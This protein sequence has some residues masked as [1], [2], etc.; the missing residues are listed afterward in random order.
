MVRRYTNEEKPENIP[1]RNQ[2]KIE[3]FVRLVDSEL[4]ERYLPGTA[5]RWTSTHVMVSFIDHADQA[6]PNS[7]MLAWVRAEDVWRVVK[8][9]E[10]SRPQV[11]RT[12]PP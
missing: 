11:R 3:V 6:F 10:S 4:G 9:A 12:G 2:G 8:R 1:A 7:V 5:M